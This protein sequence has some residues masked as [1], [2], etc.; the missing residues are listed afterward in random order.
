MGKTQYHGLLAAAHSARTTALRES[1]LLRAQGVVG[2]LSAL[3]FAISALRMELVQSRQVRVRGV[4]TVAFAAFLHGRAMRHSR[5]KP[6][7]P[8]P[9]T[10]A[11]SFGLGWPVQLPQRR[12]CQCLGRGGRGWLT[13]AQGGCRAAALGISRMRIP[14]VCVNGARVGGCAW[15]WLYVCVARGLQ[16][17]RVLE[18]QQ[19]KF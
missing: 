6:R 8:P 1:N 3:G 9:S 12:H 15:G 2:E 19:S 13:R 10:H 7:Q 14:G 17:W 18:N 5:N 11:R 4:G 16:G